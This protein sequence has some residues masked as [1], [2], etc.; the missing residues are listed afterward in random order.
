L[1]ATQRS[2]K[3]SSGF[4]NSKTIEKNRV[5]ELERT[6]FREDIKGIVLHRTVSSSAE[7][8]LNSFKSNK[9]GTHFLIG[10]D[11]T[12][13]QTASLE[14]YT[15][16]VGNTKKNDDPN[17]RNAIGIE[18]VG[19]Y[20]YD[21]EKW[22]NLTKDQAQSTADLVNLLMEVY[23]LDVSNVHNHEDISA[24]TEGEGGVVYDAIKNKLGKQEEKD[25]IPEPRVID[26]PRNINKY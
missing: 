4:I 3:A 12:I 9:I 16:H 2:L 11:G 14:K 8:T 21:N 23:G 10:K 20:N 1:A 22:E 26:L 25:E 18:V 24:K 13:Y 6:S 5:E 17:N 7:S 19:N 15:P